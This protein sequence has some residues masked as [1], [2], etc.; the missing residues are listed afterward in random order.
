[1]KHLLSSLAL[2]SLVPLS[3]SA[4]V[5]FGTPFTVIQNPPGAGVT[6]PTLRDD[7]LELFFESSGDIWRATR[8]SSDIPFLN[9]TRVE[10]LSTANSVEENPFLSTDSLRIYFTRRNSVT[11]VREIFRA[12][13]ASTTSPFGAAV[14]QGPTGGPPFVGTLGSVIGDEKKVYLEIIRPVPPGSGTPLTEQ[15]DIACATRSDV[16]QKFGPWKL[17]EGMNTLDVER[18]PFVSRD[19]R[20][21][22]YSRVGPLSG[23]PGILFFS[24]RADPSEPFPNGDPALGVNAPN[25]S[26][27]DPFWIFPGARLYFRRGTTLWAAN[28][29]IDAAYHLA[30]V[31]GIRGR[32][33]SFPVMATTDEEDVIRFDFR[34]FFDSRFLT[35]SD[36]ALAPALGG[37]VLDAILE[38]PGRLAVS[39][40]GERPLEPG[41]TPRDVIHIRFKALSNAPVGGQATFRFSNDPRINLLNVP[42]PADGSIQFLASP[43]PATSMLRL[44]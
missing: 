8:T 7:E 10:E 33:V 6:A 26:N 44:R 11:R 13:R 43:R 30:A 25:T 4:Q 35:W 17:L 3:V 27:D 28:R 41:P 37:Q 2:L 12:A 24:F 40:L 5:T 9:A 18:S 34:L 36:L 20:A 16:S 14:S 23:L 1:M 31:Q 19:D 29:T 15:S 42:R 39:I 22:I 32:T 38:G 21:L